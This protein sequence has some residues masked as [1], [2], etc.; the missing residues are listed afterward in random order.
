MSLHFSICQLAFCKLVTSPGL[1]GELFTVTVS[2]PSAD[3]P[4][5][6]SMKTLRYGLFLT[7]FI[8][9]FVLLRGVAVITHK[10]QIHVNTFTWDKTVSNFPQKNCL[11]QVTNRKTLV[12]KGRTILSCLSEAGL[13]KFC[14]FFCC[15]V[16]GRYSSSNLLC[17]L[18]TLFYL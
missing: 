1:A 18:I 16:N 14:T 8:F 17:I 4:W 10:I 2:T 7:L 3:R 12:E 13:L 15:S 5:Y 6:C 9:L 11:E